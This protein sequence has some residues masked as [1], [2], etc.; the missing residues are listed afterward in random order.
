MNCTDTEWSRHHRTR[1]GDDFRDAIWL[2]GH[3]DQS[4]WGYDTGVDSFFAQLW[5]NGSESEDPELWLTPPLLS[6]TWP[7]VLV[8]PIVA[9]A[10][11]E[12]LAVVR[13]LGIARPAPELRDRDE[14]AGLRERLFAENLDPYGV[15]QLRALDWIL[16]HNTTSP[17]TMTPA[18]C[19]ECPTAAEVDAEATMAAG[20]LTVTGRTER[21]GVEAGLLKA[22]QR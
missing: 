21:A 15:G 17:S 14:L 11:E 2:D 19:G 9:Y 4:T 12:P 7:Y 6:A 1:A 5:K 13:A 3:D 16:G 18:R 10:N 8:P 20:I 22:L